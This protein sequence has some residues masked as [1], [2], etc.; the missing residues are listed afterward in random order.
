[1]LYIN[2]FR[3]GIFSIHYIIITYNKLHHM[4]KKSLMFK[5]VHFE[6]E[7]NMNKG[8][9]KFRVPQNQEI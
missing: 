3:S 2:E 1:M 4:K 9:V 7:D 6:T 8:K 5:I